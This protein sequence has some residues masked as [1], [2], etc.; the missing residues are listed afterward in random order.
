MVPLTITAILASPKVKDA[1][2]TLAKDAFSAGKKALIHYLQPT[3]REKAAKQALQLFAEEW[4]KELEDKCEFTSALDGYRDQ[5]KILIETTAAEVAQYMEP[6][7]KDVDLTLEKRTWGELHLDELPVGFDWESV[8]RSYGQ[9]IRIYIKKDPELRAAYDTALRERTADATERAAAGIERLAGPDP[10]FDL[11]AYRHYLIDKKCN[12]LQL[13]V[14]HSSTYEFDR[15]VTLWSVFV[16]QS[17]RESAPIPEIP[18][19]I[20]QQLRTEGRIKQ[21]VDEEDPKDLRIRYKSSPVR[22]ILEVLDGNRQVVVVG[23]PGS[24]KTS[25]LRY[26]ALKW[27]KEDCGSLPL[28]VELK[29]YV[30]DRR[31]ILEY[32]Q[33]GRGVFPLSATELRKYL[34]DSQAAFY[35]D[36][37]DEIFDSSTRQ[38]VIEEIVVLSAAFPQARIVVTSRKVGYEPEQLRNANFL[39]ATLEEFSL[40]Q[41]FDFVRQWHTI[42]ER[43]DKERDLMQKRLER[44][45]S[46]STAVR[47]LAG[48]PL[49]LTMMAILNRNQELPRNRVALYREASRVLLDDW[50]ARKALPVGEFDREDKESLL[51][52]LAGDMQ[53]AEGGLAGNLIEQSRLRIKVQTF[54]EEQGH[55]VRDSRT[56][57]KLLLNQLTERNFILAYAGADRFSFVH[58]TFLEY[59]CAAWFVDRFQKKQ[60]LSL[61]ELK[62]NV[63]GRHWKDEKWHEVLRLIAGMVEEKKSEQLILFL[64]EQDGRNAKHANLMLAAGCLNEVRNRRATHATGQTLWQRFVVDVVR[65]VPLY[66]YVDWT[67][68][69]EVGPT[70][71]DAVRL[72]A[73][74]WKGENA[75]SW[76]RVAALRDRD[77]ILRQAAVQEL[78][79][80]WRDDPSTLPL[81]Q[82]CARNDDDFHVRQ[83][84]VQELVRG[85]KDDPGTLP[86]LQ[87]RARNDDNFHVRQT[88][89]QELVR[90]WKDDPGTLPLLHDRARNDNNDVRQTAVQE[91]ARGWR[92]DPGTLPLL[93][94]RARNDDDFG[95]RQATVQ[96]LARGWRDDPSTLPWLQD[97]ARNDHDFRVRQAAVQELAR[98]WRNDPSTLPW[99]QDR[100]R[101]DD[102]GVR[103]ATVQ[104][105]T[106]T[107]RGAPRTLPGPWDRMRNDNR[108]VR[109]TAVQELARGWRDDPRTLPWLQD[110]ARNDDDFHVRRTAVQELARGWRDDPGTLPLLQDRARNDNNYVREAALQEIARGWK[111]DPGTLPLLQNRVRNDDD[112]RVQNIAMWELVR[113]WRDDPGTL[114][115]L[116]DRLRN[117][118]NDSVRQTGVQELARGW[119]DDP[120]TLPLLQDRARNDNDFNVRRTAVEELA[121]GW[122]D[123]PG[124]LPL[125]QDRA[126]NDDSS[127]VRMASVLELTRGWRDDPG[128][129]PLL[130]DRARNDNDFNVRRTAVE[131]L[132]RGWRDDPGTLPLLQDC[133]HDNDYTVREAAVQELAR[134]WRDDPGTLPL[135]QD[136]ARNDDDDRVRRA[137]LRE[138]ARGWRDDPGTLPLLQDCA[139]NDD[140]TV[141]Q[142]A[143]QELARGWRD[144]PGTVHLL[145]DRARN[146]DDDRVRQAAVQE[147]ARGW[148]DD[149]NVIEAL[150]GLKDTFPPG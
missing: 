64:M 13:A 11:A 137:A 53:Q 134:G 98:G 143:V 83:T 7:T 27:A 19:E 14:M 66:A 89:V 147:L 2:Q 54:L 23:D 146:D 140:Y 52:E 127:N 9:A 15:K 62:E 3:A 90:G 122:R 110:R 59:Y 73:L 17:A 86:L 103:Q 10:G 84:S 29:E 88:S 45:L 72:M 65:F 113:G 47:E 104:E 61:N 12:A 16:G 57:A 145:Q 40:P 32:C 148:R 37:L 8:A 101:N 128:T 38:G 51:R 5:L 55:S 120:G 28:L 26:L 123:D 77:W 18:P 108:Y 41:M 30:K 142:A 115:L 67:E 74:S 87:D 6:G 43:D 94:D 22:P 97:R 99:L 129:L 24:G 68:F 107:L 81:L 126:H 132:A 78:A 111:S 1:I 82:D 150:R 130:Q 21:V 79:R 114:P 49:L 144:D 91:L 125:L 138:L 92:D 31:G 136:R 117:D 58:R 102:F 100:T 70:R 60:D 25:L 80:G 33:H 133:A 93:H 50:D 42:A 141:R 131:E 119:R 39:H 71:Q 139:H 63:F 44:A 36:G 106:R 109:Q 95:V 75:W 121:R 149:P 96:E 135:L 4:N 69:D 48:N 46:E 124:T 85:W 56:K 112:I 34:L 105:P 20:Q 76:L 118:D 35:L 116:Q